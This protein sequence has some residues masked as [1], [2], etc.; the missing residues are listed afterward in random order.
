MNEQVS[1]FMT[2]FALAISAGLIWLA[3]EG[4]DIVRIANAFFVLI[5]LVGVAILLGGFVLSLFR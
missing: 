4:V 2:A 5:A 3:V 1:G